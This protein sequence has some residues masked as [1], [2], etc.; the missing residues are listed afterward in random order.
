[1]PEKPTYEE[2][3]RR[4]QIL[5]QVN[6]SINP[7]EEELNKELLFQSVTELKQEKDTS[8]KY[9]DVAGVMILAL[10]NVGEITLINRKGCE[11][12]EGSENDILE[13]NWFD[14]FVPKDKAE[15]IKKIYYGL[16]EG[17]VEPV[18]Y[19]E[20]KIINMSGIEKI[21]AWHNT[22]L[23]DKDGKTIGSL[24][25]GADIT[26]KKKAEES[27]QEREDLLNKSQEMSSMGSFIWD[28]PNNSL[29]WSH[30]MY[31][32][33]GFN[34]ESF[35][36][37]L[38]EVSNQLIHPDDAERAHKEIQKTIGANNM[39]DSEF[40]IIRLDGQ[41]R[42]IRSKGEV[43]HNDDDI[44]VKCF[45]INQDI[46]E[47]RQFEKVQKKLQEQL[48]NA[49]EMAHLGPWEFNVAENLFTFNDYYY[50]ILHTTAEE[51]GGYQMNAEDFIN[52]FLYPDD[53]PRLEKEI[54]KAYETDDPN[55]TQQIEHRMIYADGTIGYVSI[56]F[57]I[58]KDENGNTVKTF[59]VL[60]DITERKQA[61][62]ML[63]ESEEKLARSKKMES[64]GLLAGGVAHDLNNVLS[65]IVSYPELIL[66]DLPEDSKYRKPIQTIHDS[67]TRAVA[68]VNDLLTI[69][70]GVATSKEP[71][72]LNNIIKE[73]ETSPEYKK[74]RQY[75]PFV[76]ITTDLDKDL[77]NIIGSPIH[78]RKL[79]MNLVSNASEAIE[80]RGN[81]TISTRNSYV[82]IPVKGYEDVKTGEYAVLT[83]SDDGSGIL[84]EHLERIFEPF[85]S[86]KVM[87]KSGT[88]LGLAVVWSIMQDHEGYI[89]VSSDESGT[90]FKVYFPVIREEVTTADSPLQIENY[91]GNG[92]R[93]LVV[94]DEESQ[95]EIT[96]KMLEALGYRASS[97]S[98]GEEAIEYLQ[99]RS[100]DIV[101]LDMIM[102]P[103]ISGR[104]T[105]KRILKLH[106]N[107]KAIIVSGYAE[108]K[109]IKETQRLGAGKYVKKPLTL[110]K[111]GEAI[112]EE[113]RKS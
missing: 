13:K 69:A 94:D 39:W 113:L 59:G 81:V 96:C 61:E 14:T 16:I 23:K 55:F 4:I 87:G 89:D 51:V 58:A 3:E 45:G 20:I 29:T 18:D 80:G 73:Y 74:L 70:R 57:F 60:Q 52:K 53:I 46:T 32:I 28:M 110:Q 37:D 75:H 1:M 71:L 40:R 54:Q 30:N 82:D 106:P 83:V 42:I 66:L 90:T 65:G 24:S 64:L 84:Q 49:V 108:T 15:D 97:I 12:L 38:I 19:A 17:R 36:G 25:S 50:K 86:K 22:V 92:E 101:L 88:G 56:R 99:N 102:Y 11:I 105:Y 34:E 21:I 26:E 93:V 111:T 98:S 7:D 85:F 91:K 63:R 27:L 8:Q 76:A 47:L 2:L 41:E 67:G 35:E 44:E 48:S 68:I 31:S 10:N 104:E 62:A 5:E 95:R 103:G 9:L 6:S 77:F 79:I 109:E 100:V 72:S 43:I 107:Q 78:I 33:Y 112:R